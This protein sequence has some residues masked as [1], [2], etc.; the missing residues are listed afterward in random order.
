[1]GV[2]GWEDPAST[3]FEF[4]EE[5]GPFR[6]HPVIKTEKE[7]KKTSANFF[8]EKDSI[9]KAPQLMGYSSLFQKGLWCRMS[10]VTFRKFTF[11]SSND[12]CCKAVSNNID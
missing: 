12:C 3:S 2:L 11:P 1:M 9:T 6:R 4:N 5:K 7:K 10:E 8:L